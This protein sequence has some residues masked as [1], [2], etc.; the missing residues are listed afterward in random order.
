MTHSRAAHTKLEQPTVCARNILAHGNRFTD[1]LIEALASAFE[2]MRKREIFFLPLQSYGKL[3]P[4]EL[5]ALYC[6]KREEDYK[7]VGE[8]N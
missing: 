8:T 3:H 1:S 2:R 4:I 7:V 6:V 5:F